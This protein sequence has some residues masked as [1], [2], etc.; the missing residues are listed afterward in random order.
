METT[1]EPRG[2]HRRIEIRVT[3]AL[4]ARFEAK[5][6]RTTPHPKGCWLWVGGLRQGY[7]A[8]KHDG[9]VLGA[10]VVAYVLAN[11]PVPDGRLVTH[12]CDERACCNPDHLQAGTF[13]SNSREAF[14]RRGVN[15]TRGEKSPTAY[16]TNNDVQLLRAYHMLRKYSYVRLSRLLGGN[17]NTIK[18]ILYRKNWQHLPWPTPEEAE[19]LVLSHEMHK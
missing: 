3:P 2:I 8:I 17:K 19:Q 11:G 12:D 16:F 4:R 5:V 15:V 13:S 14:D 18:N 1:T 10:H 9:K 6:D 7:G